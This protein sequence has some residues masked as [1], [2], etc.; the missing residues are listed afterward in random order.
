MHYYGTLNPEPREV[1]ATST[2]TGSQGGDA[3]E[4][5]HRNKLGLSTSLPMQVTVMGMM[6]WTVT[7]NTFPETATHGVEDQFM[8]VDRRGRPV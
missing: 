7:Q 5:N 2:T 4:Y 8:D 6:K 3:S 1:T